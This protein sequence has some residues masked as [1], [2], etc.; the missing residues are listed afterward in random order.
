MFRKAYNMGDVIAIYGLEMTLLMKEAPNTWIAIMD[1]NELFRAQIEDA[2]KLSPT[3]DY[4]E[5]MLVRAKCFADRVDDDKL[6][7]IEICQDMMDAMNDPET[8][9]LLSPDGVPWEWDLMSRSF[10]RNRVFFAMRI[11]T[12][13]GRFI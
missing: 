12:P 7:R 2:Q 11:M 8:K 5:E 9:Q 13:R 3:H 10:R 4:N 1:D 6:T